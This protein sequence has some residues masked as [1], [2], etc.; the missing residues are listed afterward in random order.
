M[1]DTS[2][3]LD[4]VHA[5][6]D[7]K[8]TASLS[9]CESPLCDIEFLPTGMKIAPRRFCS[10]Q[11]RQQASLIRRVAALLAPLGQQKAWKILAFPK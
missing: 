5:A 7:G 10:D 2:A 9:L 6:Q 8:E 1:D 11:C 4:T 3:V